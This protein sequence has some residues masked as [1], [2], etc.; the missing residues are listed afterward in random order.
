MTAILVVDDSLTVR[1]DLADA[2][3]AAGMEPVL[4]ADLGGA[5][6]AL[7]RRAFALVV[8]D[9]LLPDGDGLDLLAEI[10]RSPRHAG[11]PVMLLSS[12]A[13]VRHRV[14]G[15]TTGADDYVGKPYDPGQVVARARHL[16]RIREAQEDGAASPRPVLVVD[17]S[18]TAREGLRAALEA[19]GLEVLAAATAEEALTIAAARRPGAV[20]VDA[21]LPGM[22]G[23]GLVRAIRADPAL[24]TTPCVLLTGA[25]SMEEVAALD[26]G[27]D[28]F[29]RKDAESDDVVLLR[30]RALL[31]T[32]APTSAD[33]VAA[34]LAPK[35]VVAV[36]AGSREVE[37][38]VERLVRDGHDVVRASRA[39]EAL[40][41]LAVDRVD[42]ILVHAPSLAAAVDGCRLLRADARTQD[43]AL[44]VLGALDEPDAVVQ[45]M[46]A[47]ADDYVAPASGPEVARARVDAQLR[48]RQF[49]DEN[50]TREGYARSAQ[51]LDSISD[52]FFAVDRAWRLVYVNHALERVL[53]VARQ[54]LAGESLWERCAWLA[55]DGPRQELSRARDRQV[56]VT[57]E[58]FDPPD[59]WWEVRAFPHRIGLSAYV[60]DV[61]ER[62]HAQEIQAHLLGI[63][64]HDLR[65]PLTAVRASVEL[66]LKD[67]A[68]PPRHLRALA[69]AARSTGQMAR[70]IGDLLDYSRARLGRGIPIVAR[71]ADLD[72]I[73]RATI[74]D[75]Q[76]AHGGRAVRYV[77][78]ENGAGRWDPDRIAQILT[79]LLTNAIRYA[80]G[81]AAVTVSWRSE[82][83]LKVLSVHN[84]GPPIDRGLLRHLWEPFE[85]GASGPRTGAGLGLFI[86]REIAR[87]HG[88]TVEVASEPGRGTAFT[89]R[90]PTR[91]PAEPP[92]TP[93]SPSSGS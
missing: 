79:N 32:A 81:S 83:D 85:R 60:R 53:G 84:D 59:R 75:V 51:I 68:L 11:T 2:F 44:V 66:V 17:D 1:M 56:P 89:V 45:A 40:E 14:L 7:S 26:A 63:V 70:L 47:G 27:A 87:A 54:A 12:E 49:E 93:R 65:T 24:R 76:A 20:V 38:L 67:D 61:T 13:E 35:R 8:L 6:E 80:P 34:A 33:G 88:G 3:A 18:A 78:G 39:A 31:R 21:V 50:R 36:G 29:V 86:V 15:I 37:A 5:R 41:L 74:E 73:C 48:R 46:S 52:A 69:R 57:F 91:A 77:P 72:A 92:P 42:A 28:A 10:K 9:L 23:A 71:A 90:L 16:V 22:D 82:G 43:V 30:V 62:R 19:G 58:A 64:G 25:G 4:A 55:A